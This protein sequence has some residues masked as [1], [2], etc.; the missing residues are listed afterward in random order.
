MPSASVQPTARATVAHKAASQ[1]RLFNRATIAASQTLS[2][3]KEPPG[4]LK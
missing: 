2:S 3:K 4:S 1:Q